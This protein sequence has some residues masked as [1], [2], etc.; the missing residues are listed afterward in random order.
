MEEAKEPRARYAFHRLRAGLAVE[1][2]PYRTLDVVGYGFG[3]TWPHFSGEEFLDLDGDGRRDL[4]TMTLDFSMMQVL[5]VLTTKRFGMEMHFHPWAQLADGSFRQ[6][7]GQE[8]SAK[9][10]VNLNELR[11]GNL[12]LFAGDFDGDGAVDFVELTGGRT[13][14]IRRGHAGCAYSDSADWELR[15]EEEPR[16]AALLRVADLDGDGRADVALTRPLSGD[17]QGATS[18]VVVDLYLS[19]GA[20]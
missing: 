2:A 15:L 11:L 9:V 13:V 5:R 20:R 6:V 17:T 3:G 14:R 10:L 8:L 12:P 7:P 19:R 4:L 18:P 1:P 16:H